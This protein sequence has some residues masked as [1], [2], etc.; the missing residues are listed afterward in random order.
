MPKYSVNIVRVLDGCAL[1][2]CL[3]R[4]PERNNKR[5]H[6]LTA[7]DKVQYARANGAIVR[8]FIE[9]ISHGNTAAYIFDTATGEIVA[10][11]I[12]RVSKG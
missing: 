12:T 11:P 8:G 2:S 9:R 5:D 10:A 4:K 7:H 3:K 1:A 6:N